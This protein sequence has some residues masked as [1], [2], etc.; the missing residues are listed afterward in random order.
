MRAVAADGTI[1]GMTVIATLTVQ[2]PG[3]AGIDR[4]SAYEII[5]DG[6]PKGSVRSGRELSLALPPGRHTVRARMNWTGSDDLPVHLGPGA[7]VKLRVEP[8]GVRHAIG[9]RY[10]KLTRID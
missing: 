4:A 6:V 10:L 3:E 1:V 9:K 8:R 5:V 7:T 2:R